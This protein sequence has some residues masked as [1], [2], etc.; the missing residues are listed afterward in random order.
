M[1][2]TD[3]LTDSNPT[4]E[5][6]VAWWPD[7]VALAFPHIFEIDTGSTSTFSAIKIGKTG[8]TKFYPMKNFLNIYLAPYNYSILPSNENETVIPYSAFT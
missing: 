6:R 8:N 4:T 5:Y 7:Y 2:A 1:S 3:V